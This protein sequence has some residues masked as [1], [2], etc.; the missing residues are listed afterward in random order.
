MQDATMTASP[1]T[2]VLCILLFLAS[3]LVTLTLKS[4]PHGKAWFP[5]LAKGYL[6]KSAQR[7][8]KAPN[9]AFA[10]FLPADP[11]PSSP[12]NLKDESD[13]SYLATRVLA[14]SLLHSRASGTNARIPFLVLCTPSVSARKRARLARDGATIV[15]VKDISATWLQPQTPLEQD[16]LAKLHMFKLTQY[17]KI[18]YLDASTLVTAPMDGVFFDEATLTQAT[19]T[20]PV[21]IKEDEAALPRTYMLAAHPDYTNDTHEYPPPQDLSAMSAAFLLFT[22]SK[23]LFNY[24]HS[25]ITSESASPNISASESSADQ[26][27]LNYAH[28]REGNMPWNPLWYGWNVNRP[29]ER[30]WKGGARSFTAR[31]WDKDG[32]LDGVL[33]AMWRELRAEMEGFYTGRDVGK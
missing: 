29:S 19:L 7:P 5:T 25:L 12:D 16:V 24:Y 32:S 1:K 28:R 2:V 11:K 18:C 9:V 26:A 8:P 17:T 20:S 23:T 33:R 31:F 30:D 10:T 21:Q 3:A 15:L 22:P 13:G 4:T 27:L 6:A 14:Y